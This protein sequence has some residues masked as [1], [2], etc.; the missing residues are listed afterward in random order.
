MARPVVNSERVAVV[1]GHK[2]EDQ[3]FNWLSMVSEITKRVLEG[4][5]TVCLKY[6]LLP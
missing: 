5:S 3:S 1:E 4:I 6:A 2:E